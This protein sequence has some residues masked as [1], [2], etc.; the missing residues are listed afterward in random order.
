M[1]AV[2]KSEPIVKQNQKK[3]YS[4]HQLYGTFKVKDNSDIDKM[5]TKMQ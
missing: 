1:K 5:T 2:R 3:E 4:F